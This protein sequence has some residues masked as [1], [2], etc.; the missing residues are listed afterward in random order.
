[1]KSQIM[2]DLLTYWEDLRAGR[3]VPARADIDPR[4][5]S[6][7]L[8]HTFILEQTRAEVPQFRLAGTSVCDLL[9]MEL[10]SMP[11]HSLIA[12]D[13]RAR[14][15]Q[16]LDR[17]LTQPQIVE[18]H[19]SGEAYGNK[20]INAQILLM[21]MQDRDHD[22]SRILGCIVLAEPVL[23]APIRFDID[24]VKITRVVAGKS[25]DTQSTHGGMAEEVA[26]FDRSLK[27][28]TGTASG[29]DQIRKTPTKGGRSHL[30]VIK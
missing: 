30:K 24:D 2:L 8:P 16:I 18:L 10:R 27:S 9:G 4:A 29:I 23:R 15:A 22:V 6:N 17:M 14:F 1:M 12:P 21:P 3:L 20:R 7:C 11:A 13:H 28:V 26:A 25:M 19:V 5:I